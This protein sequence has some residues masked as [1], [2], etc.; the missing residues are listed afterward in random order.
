MV[1]QGII[2]QSH[3]GLFSLLPLGLRSVEK[4][5]KIVDSH[6]RKLGAQKIMVPSLTDGSL[7]K[8]TGRL[9]TAG[10]EIFKVLDRH[11]KMFVLAPTHE[12][13]LANILATVPVISHRNLPLRLYQI[14][15]KY[16]DEMRP[17]YGLIRSKEFMMKDLYSFDA[18]IEMAQKTY[19]HV[20]E[21]YGQLLDHIGISY[22]RVAAPSG[23]MGGDQ[24]HELHYVADIGDDTLL[25][26]EDCDYS[27]NREVDPQLDTCKACSSPRLK[28]TKG[29]EVANTFLLGTKYS[30]ALSARYVGAGSQK[31]VDL[32]MGSYGI[33]ITRLLAAALEVNSSSSAGLRWPLPLAPYTVLIITP[34]DG[35]KES[36]QTQD[37]GKEL[38]L[39]LTSMHHLENEVLWDNRDHLSIGR[40]LN[41]AKLTGYP[42]VVVIGKLYVGQTPKC[43]VHCVDDNSVH[44]L[45]IGELQQFLSQQKYSSSS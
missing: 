32:V 43:E 35:S 26:C 5:I 14:T 27:W 9:D 11:K 7:W 34:K 4:L 37:A 10:Q 20:C 18:T 6:M 16:R 38:Y 31:P 45:E 44:E 42:V 23:M 28:Q 12:E 36:L 17:R 22:S 33:G 1:S 25:T 41:D 3:N 40:R 8:K 2:H 15:N 19:D 24:S 30:K 29:I 39:R 13:S 21:I